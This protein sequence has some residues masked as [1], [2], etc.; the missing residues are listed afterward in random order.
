MRSQNPP[1][2]HARLGDAELWLS[3]P[4]PVSATHDEQPSDEAAE[5]RRAIDTLLWSSGADP[6]PFYGAGQ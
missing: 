6:T 4:A 5:H 3:P 2:L 1:V